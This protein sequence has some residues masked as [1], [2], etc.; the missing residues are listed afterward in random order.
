MNKRLC[1]ITSPTVLIPL[2]VFQL[3]V[4]LKFPFIG[5][6]MSFVEKYSEQLLLQPDDHSISAQAGVLTFYHYS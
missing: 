2:Y 1:S 6:V 3:Y 4:H 5:E